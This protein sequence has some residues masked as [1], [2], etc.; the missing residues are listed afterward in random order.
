MRIKL[1]QNLFCI[2]NNKKTTH[3]YYYLKEEKKNK[4]KRVKFHG[5]FGD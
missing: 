2:N 4:K 3:N 1:L 5:H